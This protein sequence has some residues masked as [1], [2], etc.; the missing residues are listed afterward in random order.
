MIL[1]KPSRYYSGRLWAEVSEEFGN[2]GGVADVE[3][4]DRSSS[5]HGGQAQLEQATCKRRLLVLVVHLTRDKR[6]QVK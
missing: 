3:V 1:F 6:N 4:V 2:G 5:D